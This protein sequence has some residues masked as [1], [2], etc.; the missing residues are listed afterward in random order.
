[1]WG[2][3]KWSW[4]EMY[5]SSSARSSSSTLLSR[6]HKCW[7]REV[8]LSHLSFLIPLHSSPHCPESWAGSADSLLSHVPWSLVFRPA[9]GSSGREKQKAETERAWPSSFFPMRLSL[10]SDWVTWQCPTGFRAV[11]SLVCL[12]SSS[13]FLF[14]FQYCSFLLLFQAQEWEVS[15]FFLAVLFL[16]SFHTV[17][18]LANYLIS[19]FHI[20][21]VEHAMFSLWVVSFPFS[22]RVVSFPT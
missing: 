20:I 22:S 6:P 16:F 8:D 13:L 1:M 19:S 7:G 18:K 4:E 10:L 12:H 5:N 17:S 11:L 14:K 15:L 9:S 21:E 3:W 2:H